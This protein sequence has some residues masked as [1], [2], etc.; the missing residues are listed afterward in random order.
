MATFTFKKLGSIAFMTSAS[1]TIDNIANY[2]TSWSARE[3]TKD[4]DLWDHE[5]RIIDEYFPKPPARILDLGCGAGRTTAG[6]AR[7]GFS[8]VAIDLSDQL[9]TLAR[10]RHPT[11]DFRK[12][13]ATKLEFEDESFDSAIFSYNGIDCIYPVEGR[14]HCMR[15]VFRILKPGGI[16]ALS[17]HNMIGSMFSGGF[18]YLRGHWNA[19]K[20]LVR[21]IPNRLAWSWYPAY[22][23][24]GGVQ[25]LYS[26]PPGRTME[27]LSSVG[28]DVLKVR[29]YTGEE[30][31][32][33]LFFHQSHVHFVARKPERHPNR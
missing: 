11:L 22:E 29:G 6:L 4:S 20:F 2:D 28:F 23:D 15:E 21:Q 3:Y 10:E 25:Y 24:G 16:F 27:Q 13:D 18:F 30:N 14:L 12:M 33:K 31:P 17:S 8:V 5:A 9:L 19:F 1:N 26:A 7:R 32:R